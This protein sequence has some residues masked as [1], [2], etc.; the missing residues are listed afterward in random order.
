MSPYAKTWI[1]KIKAGPV[2]KFGKI[3]QHLQSIVVHYFD[4]SGI[5]SSESPAAVWHP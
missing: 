4:F 1:C 5:S 2:Q 3:F